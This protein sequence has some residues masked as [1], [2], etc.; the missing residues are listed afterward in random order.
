M[1]GLRSPSRTPWVSEVSLLFRDR[2][3]KH[4]AESCRG[5]FLAENAY[6][7]SSTGFSCA[8]QRPVAAK[9]GNEMPGRGRA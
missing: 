4:K 1:K 6:F 9:K 8:S 2:I 5:W 7:R 3:L